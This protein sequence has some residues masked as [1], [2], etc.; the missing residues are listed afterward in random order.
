M[1]TTAKIIEAITEH[2]GERCQ[3][4]ESTCFCCQAWQEFDDL[5]SELAEANHWRERHSKDSDA[6]GKQNVADF[7]TIK[8]LRQQLNEAN[9]ACAAMR[10]N[11]E[12]N[13][14][15]P[16]EQRQI[17]VR[18][19]ET[20]IRASDGTVFTLKWPLMARGIATGHCSGFVSAP[21]TPVDGSDKSSVA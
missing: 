13:P 6:R 20:L 15:E 12:R 14:M 9:A 10:A 3:D 16:T 2:W 8:R 7:E 21:Q 4:Y 18:A 5:Q 1:T 19:G 17:T 11:P